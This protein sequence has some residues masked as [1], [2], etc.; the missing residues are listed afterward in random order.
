M[1]TANVETVDGFAWA[2]ML[3]PKGRVVSVFQIVAADDHLLLLCEPGQ[4]ANTIERLSKYAIMD[5]VEFESVEL[6]VHRV[7]TDPASVWTAPPVFEAPGDAASDANAVEVRR[8]EAG[9]PR[10]GVDIGEDY[11]PFETPLVRHID[12]EKGC[13]IGQEPVSRVHFRGAP[14][15]MLRGLVVD[16]EGAVEVGATVSHADRANGGT[17]TSAAVSPELGAIALAYVHRSVN[18]PGTAV[19]IGDRAATVVDL[20]FGSDA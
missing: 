4:T 1:C 10:F 14:N 20:P 16:G 15:K 2:A 13:Y 7:W 12:Y 3:T 17:I 6:D 5:D 19:T 8:I 11:F 9:V 18:E